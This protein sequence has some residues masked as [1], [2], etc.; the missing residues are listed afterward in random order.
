M[1]TLSKENKDEIIQLVSSRAKFLKLTEPIVRKFK[2]QM[3]KKID[4]EGIALMGNFE[5]AGIAW[6]NDSIAHSTNKIE[7]VESINEIVFDAVGE[8][9]N[10]CEQYVPESGDLEI[11]VTN[12]NF[13]C[14]MQR[15]CFPTILNKYSIV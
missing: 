7:S 6:E 3:T 12:K 9:Y 4:G 8:K 2:N 11:I 13:D 1:N 10:V 5:L 14:E 15:F